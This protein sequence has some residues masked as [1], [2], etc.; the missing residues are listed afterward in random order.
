M[1]DAQK[2]DQN[3][4]NSLPSSKNEMTL[5]LQIETNIQPN[6]KVLSQTTTTTPDE[7]GKVIEIEVNNKQHVTGDIEIDRSDDNQSEIEEEAIADSRE[8]QMLY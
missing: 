3:S 1:T 6:E 4:R 8:R 7:I 2:N 5:V